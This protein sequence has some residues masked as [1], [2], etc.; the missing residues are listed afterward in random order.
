MPPRGGVALADR[1]SAGEAADLKFITA[2][3]GRTGMPHSLES[4]L[5]GLNHSVALRAATRIEHGWRRV[6]WA[7]HVSWHRTEGSIMGRHLCCGK[8]HNYFTIPS[9]PLGH[10]GIVGCMHSIQVRVICMVFSGNSNL[11]LCEKE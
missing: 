6:A 8:H 11:V 10:A 7:E 2:T 4:A 5:E 3:T 9:D 1:S